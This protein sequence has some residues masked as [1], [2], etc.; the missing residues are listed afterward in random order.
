[1]H[2]KLQKERRTNMMKYGM[3]EILE[4]QARTFVEKEFTAFD[5]PAKERYL[6]A[7]LDYIYL[8]YPSSKDVA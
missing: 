6:K 2:E 5:E 8:N 7:I 4:N 3:A 1:M